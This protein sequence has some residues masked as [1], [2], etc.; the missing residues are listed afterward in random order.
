MTFKKFLKPG[1]D[2]ML[3]WNVNNLKH[4]FIENKEVISLLLSKLS[5]YV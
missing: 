2:C 1:I 5:T 3:P 4:D